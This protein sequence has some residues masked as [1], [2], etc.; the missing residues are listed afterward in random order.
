M[1]CIARSEWPIGEL[2]RAGNGS[3][4]APTAVADDIAHAVEQLLMVLGPLPQ[5]PSSEPEVAAAAQSGALA[6]PARA[7]TGRLPISATVKSA[8][9]SF[10][11]VPILACRI[12]SKRL[13]RL[14]S[15]SDQA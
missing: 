13:S 15:R 5:Q 4:T 2:A 12:H 6:M 8:A 10:C 7:V 11:K 3:F 1:S 14:G 9:P